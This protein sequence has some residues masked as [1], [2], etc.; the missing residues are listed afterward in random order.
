MGL[1]PKIEEFFSR[2]AK[3][4]LA[5]SLNSTSDEVRGKIMPVNR[6]FSLDQLIDTLR[7]APLKPRDRITIEY[8]MLHDVTD[9]AEDLKRLPKLLQG[10]RCKVNLIPYNENAGLGFQAPPRH[11]VDH[12]AKTLRGAEFNTTVRWSKGLD[13]AAACGQLAAD[14]SKAL[15]S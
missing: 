9:T 8:V 3:A 14:H 13:I 2:G 5:V 15:A 1:V 12:W 7:R 11:W 4:K 10:V 6:R